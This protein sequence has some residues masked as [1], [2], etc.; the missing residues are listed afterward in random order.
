VA[1][2]EAFD[3][4]T[5]RSRLEAR[6]RAM[7][8]TAR[9][10]L[11]RCAL[12][13]LVRTPPT[14]AL[15]HVPPVSLPSTAALPIPNARR[16]R[17]LDAQLAAMARRFNGYSAVVIHD[18]ATG[19]TA[20]WNANARFPAAST[21]KLGVLVAA[22]RAARVAPE[23]SDTWYDLVQLTRW[24]SNLAANRL[25]ARLGRNAVETALRRLGTTASTYTGVYRVG[26]AHGAAPSQPPLVS[27][28]V[29]TARDLAT[30][31]E[32]IHKAAFGD[33]AALR[34]TGLSRHQARLPLGLLLASKPEGDNAGLFH[35]ALPAGM[36]VAQ[37]NGW[38]SD[39]FH[40]AAILYTPRGPVVCVVL[41]YRDGL[42]RAEATRLGAEV[43]RLALRR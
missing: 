26:T 25:Y 18:L 11:S 2:A 6:V 41:T 27:Q 28:R 5:D 13:R 21:V 9:S 20:S 38:L 7:A 17:G 1:A 37:K 39:A 10:A 15:A 34:A 4:L 40:T 31:L 33:R 19:R 3:R 36:P 29:T 30:V 35:S 22:L 43:V 23:R 16:D 32:T 24:S 14:P 8:R 42:T 12:G